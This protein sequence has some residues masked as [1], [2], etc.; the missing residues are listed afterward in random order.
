MLFSVCAGCRGI[1]NLSA[2]LVCE[3][4]SED[5][6][7]FLFN[8]GGLRTVAASLEASY[9]TSRSL[10]NCLPAASL[11]RGVTAVAIDR[12]LRCSRLPSMTVDAIIRHKKRQSRK[13]KEVTRDQETTVLVAEVD[14]PIRG[15]YHAEETNKNESTGEHTITVAL[16]DA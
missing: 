14:A 2:T 9:S 7:A 5:I 16:H 11:T 1:G 4:S 10:Y 3:R 12:H 13:H 8:M 6:P 15:D